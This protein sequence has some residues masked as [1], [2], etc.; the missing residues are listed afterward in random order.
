M[1]PDHLGLVGIA[2]REAVHDVAHG[3]ACRR[4]QGTHVLW[5]RDA[6]MARENQ[7]AFGDVLGVVAHALERTG[8]FD[9]AED[10]A[11]V[12]GHGLAARDDRK[13]AGFDL[14]LA[15]IQLRVARD[16]ALGGI[17]VSFQQCVHG[18]LQL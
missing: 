3:A 5:D 15:L 12:I 10:V 6:G 2:G 18:A 11:Q 14:A 8:N 13:R 1:L 17:D 7:R 9:V 16:D 4:A